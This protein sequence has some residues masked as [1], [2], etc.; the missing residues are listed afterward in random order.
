MYSQPLRFA[1]AL[2]HDGQIIFIT[3]LEDG[4]WCAALCGTPE[5]PVV[6]SKLRLC[7]SIAKK[8]AHSSAIAASAETVQIPTV[9]PKILKVSAE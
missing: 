2:H 9:L 1:K 3:R 5:A 8:L 4:N 6:Q 7:I